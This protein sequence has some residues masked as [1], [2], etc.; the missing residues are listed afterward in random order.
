M[1]VTQSDVVA[2]LRAKGLDVIAEGIME[3]RRTFNNTIKYILMSTSSNFG[4][5]FSAAGASF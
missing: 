2:A 4:N 3:G 1:D 5:M